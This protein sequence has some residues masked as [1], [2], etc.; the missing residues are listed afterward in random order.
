MGTHF[1]TR[2]VKCILPSGVLAAFLLLIACTK[3]PDSGT[4]PV[5]AVTNSEVNQWVADSMRYWYYW[6]N[7]IPGDEQLNFDQDPAVFFERLLNRPTD[8]FS[9]IQN[10]RELKGELSGIIKTSGLGYGFFGINKGNGLI[11]GLAVRYVLKGSPADMAGIK[12]GDL[13]VELD[14]QE[15]PVDAD[16]Y[17]QGID[18]LQGSDPFTLTK[19]VLDDDGN[20]VN[21]GE[22]VGLTPVEGFR[23]SAILLDTVL[24]AENGTK[25]GYLFYNRFLATQAQELVDAFVKFKQ[26]GVQ[27]LIVDERYNSGGALAIAGLLSALIHRDFDIS[28]PF[29]RMDFNSGL[30][31]AEYTYGDLFGAEN[32]DLVQSLNLGLGRVF[33]LATSSSASASELLINN[34]RPFLG[35]ANVIHIGGTTVGKDEAS[36][37]IEN[38]DPRFADSWG[39]Q[40]IVLKY[41]NKNG[42]GGF[43]DGLTPQYAV[44]EES[45]ALQPIGSKADPLLGTALGIIDPGMRAR[46]DMQMSIRRAR[47]GSRFKELPGGGQDMSDA[48][49]LDVTEL[50]KGKKPVLR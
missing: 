27:E 20:I 30:K 45:V 16:G 25:V 2:L 10:I 49:P 39:I 24:T 47:S 34:L 21:T 44:A 13:F 1:L 18:A 42:E 12:R 4:G 5:G 15:M 17:V 3:E 8:R 22:T 33:I 36:Y 19:A 26:A 32:N 50:L 31:D 11:A 7:A 40:P 46:L 43:T 38:T 9:W 37:T 14:G 28:S 48:Q 23:E 41:Q 35:N 6:N 29:I